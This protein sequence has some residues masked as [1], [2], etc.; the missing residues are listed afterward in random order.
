MAL[1]VRRLRRKPCSVRMPA[2]SV[3]VRSDAAKWFR[4]RM[5]SVPASSAGGWDAD[6]LGGEAGGAC[7]EAPVKALGA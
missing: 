1:A 3:S 4:Y 2:Y 6:V 5:R 7:G